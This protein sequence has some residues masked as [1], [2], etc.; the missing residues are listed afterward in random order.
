MPKS[1]EVR[2]RHILE[3]A[4]EALTFIRGHSPGDLQSNRQL[5]L[6][7]VQL[8]QI[9]GEAARSVSPEYRSEHPEVPWKQMVGMRD[10]LI[11]RYY[12]V[13]WRTVWQTVVDDLPPLIGHLKHLLPPR[14]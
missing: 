5:S 9:V 2:L 8:L 12:D 6:S 7:L 10:R 13:N 4:E 3:A 1:N 11:H 14:A